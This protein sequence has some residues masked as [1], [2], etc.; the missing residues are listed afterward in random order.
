MMGLKNYAEPLFL[1]P[2]SRRPTFLFRVES[3]TLMYT[4][5]ICELTFYHGVTNALLLVARWH[6]QCFPKKVGP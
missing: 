4:L 6:G 1:V 2:D 5:T 3:I